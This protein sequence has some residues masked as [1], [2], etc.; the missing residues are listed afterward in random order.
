[1]TGSPNLALAGNL[2]DV[3]DKQGDERLGPD[4]EIKPDTVI[5]AWAVEPSR[6]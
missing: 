4:G 6:A 2:V 5:R 1:M 3:A